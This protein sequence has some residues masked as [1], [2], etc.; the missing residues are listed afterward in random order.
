M[1]TPKPPTPGPVLG[2]SISIEVAAEVL[3][4]SR[5]SVYNYIKEGKLRT[6]RTINGSQRVLVESL[7]IAAQSHLNT[8]G[9]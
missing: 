9:Q 3:N 4:L 7:S 8:R 6:V 5:R 1:I 2:R